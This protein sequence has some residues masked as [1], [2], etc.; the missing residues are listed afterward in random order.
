MIYIG[1]ALNMQKNLFRVY[2]DIIKGNTFFYT[3]PKIFFKNEYVSDKKININYLIQDQS[4]YCW[5][6][7]SLCLAGNQNLAINR[8]NSYLFVSLK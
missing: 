3:Y 8:V 2:G 7:P 5:D 6:T 4:I 1:L